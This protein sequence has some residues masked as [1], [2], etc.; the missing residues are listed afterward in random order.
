MLLGA[1]YAPL[2]KKKTQDLIDL[3][4][5]KKGDKAV[6][7]GAG[8]G[9]IVIELARLGAVAVGYEINPLLVLIGNYRIKKAGLT[10]NAKMLW[11]DFWREDLSSFDIITIYLS[12]N[13]MGRVEKKVKKEAKKGA[14]IGVNFFKFPTWKEDK[15]LDTLYLYKK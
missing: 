12:F 9:R 10:H 6:D 4:K 2:G 3:L 14:R 1:P 5:V 13:S 11:K 15:K 7:L 8:D